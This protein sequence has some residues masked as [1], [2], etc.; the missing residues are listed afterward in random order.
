M[1]PTKSSSASACSIGLP[2]SRT[3]ISASSWRRSTCS[4]PTLR[5][6]AARSATVDDPAQLS[7]ASSARATAARS[8]SSLIVGYSLTVSPVAG[9][10]TAYMLSRLL[11]VVLKGC[12]DDTNARLPGERLE[13]P[14]STSLLD[15]EVG[16]LAGAV[17]AG[18][19]ADQC[20][21]AGLQ[22]QRE[23]LVRARLDVADLADVPG[24]VG[25]RALQ[26]RPGGLV[27]AQHDELVWHSAAVPDVERHLPRRSL[28]R[29]R[30]DAELL[31]GDAD[32]AWGDRGGRRGRRRGRNRSRGGRGVRLGVELRCHG[33]Q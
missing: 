19:V 22:L 32:L 4:S 13:V 28:R 16:V 14:R 9:L 12:R 8:S 20:V 21:V 30:V 25:L 11:R 17:V 29:G 6:S 10:I 5:T 27:G 33:D 18:E 24:L 31:H 7:R 3:M 26:Q 15:R 23:R 2:I 1:S